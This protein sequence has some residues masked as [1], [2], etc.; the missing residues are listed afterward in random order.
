MLVTVNQPLISEHSVEFLASFQDAFGSTALIA[1]I[2]V[3]NEVDIISIS[4]P[5]FSLGENGSIVSWIW[6]YKSDGGRCGEYTITISLSY[7][8]ENDFRAMGIYNIELPGSHKDGGI[9]GSIMGLLPII[10][11]IIAVVVAAVVLIKLLKNRKE[12]ERESPT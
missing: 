12:A 5:H 8:E 10:I 7:C 4:E 9:I 3:T 1:N 2:R 11:I 6:D